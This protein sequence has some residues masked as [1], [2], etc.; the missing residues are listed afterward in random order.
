M[1][2]PAPFKARSRDKARGYAAISARPRLFLLADWLPDEWG[3]LF[4]HVKRGFFV[5]KCY[6]ALAGRSRATAGAWGELNA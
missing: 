5:A 4:L 6:T 3:K 2:R 1:P